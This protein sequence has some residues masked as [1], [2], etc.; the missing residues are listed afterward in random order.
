M[1]KSVFRKMATRRDQERAEESQTTQAP[2]GP[3]TPTR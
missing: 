3:K 2:Q 1:S